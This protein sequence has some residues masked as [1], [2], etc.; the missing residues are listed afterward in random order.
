MRRGLAVV[1]QAQE[2][3]VTHVLWT[4][5]LKGFFGMKAS[6]SSVEILGLIVNRGSRSKQSDTN[7]NN[8]SLSMSSSEGAGGAPPAGCRPSLQ[9]MKVRRRSPSA[10]SLRV[11]LLLIG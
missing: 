3:K 5:V 11:F 4:H 1:S 7:L 6:S 2:M 10:S 8:V 9:Q